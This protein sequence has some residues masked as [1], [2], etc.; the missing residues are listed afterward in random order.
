MKFQEVV[1]DMILYFYRHEYEDKEKDMIR[2]KI[3]YVLCV[4]CP[5]EKTL[6]EN[7]KKLKG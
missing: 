6:E 1:E 2:R 7:I 4:M 3:L 5:D